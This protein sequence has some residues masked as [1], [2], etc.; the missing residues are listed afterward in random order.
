LDSKYEILFKEN[1]SAW[2]FFNKQA[3]SYQ[4]LMIHWVMNAKQEKTRIS[5]LEKIISASELQKRT[6]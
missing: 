6:D 2:E 1:K 3:P 5:R 4:K